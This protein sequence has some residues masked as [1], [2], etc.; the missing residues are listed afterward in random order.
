MID[1]LPDFDYGGEIAEKDMY[2]KL[3]PTS[4]TMTA[5]IDADL[6]PY[7]VGFIV[8]ELHY[9]EA[10][11]LV[12]DGH[13]KE[14]RDTPQFENAFEMLCKSLNYW[15]RKAGCDSAILYS[16]DSKTNFRL[17]IA[18]S[19]MYKGQRTQGKPPFFQELKDEMERRLGCILSNGIEADDML[20]IEASRRTKL[21]GVA[22]G[23]SQHK[24]FCDCVVVS[25]DKDSTITPTNNLNPDTMKMQWITELGSL[26]PKYKKA[27]V[28]RYEQ[29]GTG[30][31]WKRGDKAG[32]EKTKRILVG[33]QPSS[34]IEKLEGTG[35][36]FFYSQILTGDVA[37]NYKGLNGC[38]KT[39]AYNALDNCK[40][41]RELYT[42]V[43]GMYKE[44]YGNGKHWC[45]HFKGTEAYAEQ[46][47]DINGSLP[48]DW[49]FWKN[50]GAW[51]TAYDRMLEQGRLAWMMQFEG[52]IWRLG[53]GDLIDAND[54]EFWVDRIN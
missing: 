31:F 2:F 33:E 19:D 20:S 13:F 44:H 9:I 52:D 45:Q 7:R 48:D 40:S 54:K 16:T 46:Y 4:G 27:M 41:E 51:L 1:Y 38:G 22:A 39:A 3:W 49:S 24:E 17:S 35:L 23:S 29:V 5:L 8:D 50:K 47:I 42:V 25:S 15:V 36:K 37:D 14:V 18:Y 26:S 32:Q 28:R 11:S 12:R 43:L 6:L 53:K 10:L 21:L 30:E 34:A